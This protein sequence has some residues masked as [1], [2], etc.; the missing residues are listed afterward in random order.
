[1]SINPLPWKLDDNDC[2]KIINEEGDIIAEDYTFKNMDDFEALPEL[3]NNSV[4][5]RA[6]SAV[7]S[8]VSQLGEAGSKGGPQKEDNI[9]KEYKA[10]FTKCGGCDACIGW[11]CH[12]ENNKYIGE[13]IASKGFP[14]WCPLPEPL[15]YVDAVPTKHGD[16][17]V[18]DSGGNERITLITIHK[19]THMEWINFNFFGQVIYIYSNEGNKGYQFS[20]RT[21]ER[22]G[23]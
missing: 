3:V 11:N 8:M 5:E 23:A 2:A 12:M 22:C 9:E 4:A 21:V 15:H 13:D 14:D 19:T 18:K 17:W 6:K 10:T 16:Y 20:N 7:Q 1:M